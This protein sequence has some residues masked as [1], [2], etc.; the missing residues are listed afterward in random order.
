MTHAWIDEC[1]YHLVDDPDEYERVLERLEH[2]EKFAF[3]LET[4]GLNIFNHVVVGCSITIEPEQGWYF[5]FNHKRGKNLPDG[6]IKKLEKILSDPLKTVLMYN[7]KFDRGFMKQFVGIDIPAYEDVMVSTYLDDP[8][9]DDN[10]LKNCGRKYLG[11]DTMELSFFFKKKSDIDFSTLDAK[12]SYK[13]A[14][15][16]TDLTYRLHE[17]LYDIRTKYKFIWDLENRVV[18]VLQRMEAKGFVIDTDRINR[19]AKELQKKKDTLRA[20]CEKA[21]P[22]TNIDS[23]AQI[24]TAL[25]APKPKGLGIE[26]PYKTPTG[27]PKTDEK[28]LTELSGKHSVIKKITEFREVAKALGS[29]VEPLVANC[30]SG[31]AHFSF[32]SCRVPTGRFAASGGGPGSHYCGINI[33]SF[34]KNKGA[35]TVPCR[36]VSITDTV[37]IDSFWPDSTKT[38]TEQHL[39]PEVG[40]YVKDSEKLKDRLL[41]SPV[42]E[43]MGEHFVFLIESPGLRE[44]DAKVTP[45]LMDLSELE[46]EYNLRSFFKPRDGYKI[47]DIDY[48]NQELRVAACF[49]QEPVFLDAFVNGRDL[50]WE[51]AKKAF[52]IPDDASVDKIKRNIAKTINFGLLYGG[53]AGT[54]ARQTG[55]P[56]REAEKI[57][58]DYFAAVPKL[59]SWI[60]YQHAYVMKHGGVWT[61]FRRWRPL[62]KWTKSKDRKDHGY[63][64]RSAVNNP[65]QGCLT[66]DTRVLTNEGY[67]KIGELLNRD[68]SDLKVWTGH[69]W[70]T[71]VV[72]SRGLAQSASIILDN[73][74]I[75]R[76][77]DR[78][79]VLVATDTGYTFKSIDQL[80]PNDLV[81][82]S[83]AEAKEVGKSFAFKSSN[84]SQWEITKDKWSDFCY[85][86]GYHIGDGTKYLSSEKGCLTFSLGKEDLTKNL[87]ELER[88]VSSIGL[89]ITGLRRTVGSKGESYQVNVHS[90]DLVKVIENEMG[91]PYATAGQKRIPE[92]LWASDLPSRIAFLK[93]LYAADG[94][95]KGR[96]DW[97]IHLSSEDLVRELQVFCR[98]TGIRSR[99]LKTSDNSWR[100]D[101]GITEASKFLDVTPGSSHGGKQGPLPKFISDLVTKSSAGGL[102]ALQRQFKYILR[103]GTRGISLDRFEPLCKELNIDIPFPLYDMIPVSQIVVSRHQIPIETYTLS[104]DDDCHHF[105]SEG[106]ISKN[107]SADMMKIA[108]VKID[109][110]IRKHG[111][112]NDCHMLSTVHDELVF[113]VKEERLLEIVPKLIE[114]MTF[115]LQGWIPIEVE[116]DIGENWGL[117]IG[118]E[119][120]LKM[121]GLK[122]EANQQ[123]TP[124]HLAKKE[125]PEEELHVI[126]KLRSTL[127]DDET[128]RMRLVLG[129]PK[130]QGARKTRLK[131]QGDTF[132]IPHLIDASTEFY[133]QMLPYLE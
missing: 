3:D 95:K 53:N 100:I 107:T 44:A 72:H 5:P 104:V 17:K 33:Q 63:A 117:L 69:S 87:P 93:G 79:S 42:I 21:L 89:S 13:Y 58:K 35:K 73:G 90:K 98:F 36:K 31:L 11:L 45:V 2:V 83:R 25:F 91:Y 26:N 10:S 40:K 51:M 75:L 61:Y 113:E 39:L 111:W 32:L 86:L 15:Q 108:M 130:F 12:Q 28:T 132:D 38:I 71:F 46:G 97:N 41:K 109:R 114:T 60:E 59:K 82:V 126:L 29:Y 101:F 105:D 118:W 78:H 81:C 50:H 18:D 62:D 68:T 20:E 96:G 85:L 65:V 43:H 48:A 30:P 121:Q 115:R 34:P 52:H 70:V 67:F 7:A 14:C 92:I 88:I 24:G 110:M 124:V 116:A 47:V 22:G 74:Q 127:S 19:I 84:G 106:P 55:I 120:F 131:F 23:P 77:D 1:D 54:V 99:V 112:E 8:N 102:T 103:K 56:I 64:Q 49:S 122:V 4:N 133:K 76:C 125:L 27:K 6:S 66:F 94:T 123:T 9:E 119:K 128:N 129:D 16:D 57:V 37:T 80:A